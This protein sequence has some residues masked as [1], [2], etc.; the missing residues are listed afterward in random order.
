MVRG[1]R[2]AKQAAVWGDV[3]RRDRIRGFVVPPRWPLSNK[4]GELINTVKEGRLSIDSQGAQESKGHTRVPMV[5]T[6][7]YPQ[8]TKKPAL[9][10]YKRV[11]LPRMAGNTPGQWCPPAN[12]IQNELYL[13]NYRNI[14]SAC[15]LCFDGVM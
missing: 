9:L 10:A 4:F 7:A 5:A 14:D 8:V 6:V 12:Y 3:R 13:Y 11:H 2:A 15:R 1:A